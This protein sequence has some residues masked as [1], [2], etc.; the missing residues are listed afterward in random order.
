[1]E[2]KVIELEAQAE[3]ATDLSA[4]QLEKR[5]EAL[6]EADEIDAELLALKRG[7]NLS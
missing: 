3:L 4:G 1:M 5:F 2:D 7:M 6:G